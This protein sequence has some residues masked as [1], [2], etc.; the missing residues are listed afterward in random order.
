MIPSHNATRVLD[1]CKRGYSDQSYN[2][3]LLRIAT[4]RG[5]TMNSI[6]L[7]ERKFKQ[8]KAHVYMYLFAW[9]WPALGTLMR[10][11]KPQ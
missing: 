6:R 1:T 11:M 10:R 3:R 8:G 9:N 5:M 2:E 4:D 7:A